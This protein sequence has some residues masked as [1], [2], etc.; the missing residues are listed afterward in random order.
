MDH[1]SP[2]SL[3]VLMESSLFYRDYYHG[4]GDAFGIRNAS[5]PQQQTALPVPTFPNEVLSSS[6]VS[7]T[8]LLSGDPVF[9]ERNIRQNGALM[10]GLCQGYKASIHGL[11]VDLPSP[12][13]GIGETMT[14]REPTGL[15][16]VGYPY[17]SINNVLRESSPMGSSSFACSTSSPSS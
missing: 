9:V 8:T 12:D 6:N 11:T 16:Q 13:S 5:L 1:C 17:A 7:T 14:P 4:N 10:P 3:P 2:V 15:P